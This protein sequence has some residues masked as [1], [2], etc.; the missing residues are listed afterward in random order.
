MEQRDR[1][2]A[3][4][5]DFHGRQGIAGV[6]LADRL[7]QGIL[8][9]GEAL[10]YAIDIGSA[11][12]RAHR[13]GVIHG[14]L[15]AHAILLTASGARIASPSASRDADALP[16]RAPEQ[17][18]GGAPDCRSDIFAFGV[19]LYEM[20]GGGRAFRGE[21]PALDQA[22][23]EKPPA[24]LMGSSPVEEALEG[25]IAGC[26]EKDPAQRRQ[27]VQNA[28][29]E[30]K[31]AGRTLTRPGK[32]EPCPA[33]EAAPPAAM[34][35]RAVEETEIRPK[36][37]K[38]FSPVRFPEEIQS[39]RDRAR[40]HRLMLWLLLSV[41]VLFIASG[42]WIAW[43]YLHQQVQISRPTGVPLKN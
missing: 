8:P 40:R 26:L 42:G 34:G 32:P 25:V 28:V 1:V 5:P 18:A 3:N 39:A 10:G 21:G 29:I 16:Y 19:L 4:E 30:L 9:A 14:K 37:P 35:Q 33:A 38:I 24:A 22:I 31:L 6:P 11:L 17:V 23:L 7:A 2:K 13:R 36:R 15:S 27:R 41:S 43:Q 20:A 12:H